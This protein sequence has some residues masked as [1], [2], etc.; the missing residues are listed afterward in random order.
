MI[1]TGVIDENG[2]IKAVKKKSKSVIN[3]YQK[4]NN[5]DDIE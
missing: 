3:N 5:Y 1:K 2:E 4:K